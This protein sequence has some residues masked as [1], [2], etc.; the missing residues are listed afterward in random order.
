MPSAAARKRPQPSDTSPGCP[1]VGG[2][3]P[4]AQ[5]SFLCSGQRPH[6]QLERLISP[7]LN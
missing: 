5:L 6:R 4:L 7:H 3:S 2:L 1:S